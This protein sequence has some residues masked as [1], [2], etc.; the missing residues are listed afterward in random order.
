MKGRKEARKER[1]KEVG[2]GVA[3][4]SLAITRYAISDCGRRT[5]RT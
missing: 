5:R 1:R 4:K 3:K 2:L